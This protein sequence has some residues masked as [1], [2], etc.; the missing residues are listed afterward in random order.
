MKGL[1][2]RPEEELAPLRRIEHGKRAIHD[3]QAD[4]VAGNHDHAVGADRCLQ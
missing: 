2:E 4:A 3:L 1:S